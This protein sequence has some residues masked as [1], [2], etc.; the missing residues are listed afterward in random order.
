MK[1]SLHLESLRKW[2]HQH[3]SRGHYEEHFCESILNLDQWFRCGL[4]YFSSRALAAMLF[5][6]AKGFRH[7]LLR[8]LGGVI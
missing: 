1:V 3:F 8:A 7:F 6:G 5:G 4:K 2:Y